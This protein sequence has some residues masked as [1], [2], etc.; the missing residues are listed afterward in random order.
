LVERVKA[1]AQAVTD[2]AW[3][4][5]RLAVCAGERGASAPREGG[6]GA[7]RARA[8]QIIAEPGFLE[9]VAARG[10]RLRAGLR[11]ALAGNAHVKEVRGQGLICGVQLD[12][13]RPGRMPWC[14][15]A[16]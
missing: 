1:A 2:S 11:E 4:P 9:G 7:D 8:A 5:G 13:V 3:A 15:A 12:V 16:A 10:E 14:H 6:G